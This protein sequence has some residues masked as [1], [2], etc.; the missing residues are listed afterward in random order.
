[1][2]SLLTKALT[3]LLMFCLAIPTM[4]E[5]SNSYKLHKYAP[6]NGGILQYVSPDGKWAVINLGTSA[7]GLTCPSELMNM[8]TGE[9]FGVKYQGRELSFNNVSNEDADGNVTIVGTFSLRPYAYRFNPSTPDVAGKLT[10]FQ[11]RLNWANGTLN[12]VTPDGKYAV[13]YFTDYTGKEAAG[14]EF[15]GEFWFD[16]L[17][18][19]IEKGIVMETPGLPTGDRNGIDQHAM[20]FNDITPDGRYILGEREWYMPSE[21]FQ[22]IY[23]V[24]KQDY[25]PI[26]FR[27]EGNRMIPEN[28]I[29][30]LDF[31]IMSHNGRYVGGIAVTYV[32]QDGSDMASEGRSPFRYDLETGEMTIFSDAESTA[33]D[34]GC[35]TD[36]GTIFGNP[37]TGSPLRNFRIF[38]QDKFWIPFSQLCQQQ[39]GFNFSQKTGFEFSGTATSVSGDGK[40]FVAFS[41][42][43]G[44]SFAFNFGKSVEEA[45]AS[46]DLLSNY[47]V[48]P[49][50]GAVTSRISTVEVNFGRAVQILG[51]GNTHVHLYKKGTDGGSDV[52]ICDGVSTESGIQF[53]TGSKNTVQF[54]I[55][56]RY[57]RL[58]NGAEYYFVIDEGA[59][60]PA[61]DA[62]MV[63]KQIRIKYIGRNDEPVRVIKCEPEDGVRMTNLDVQT[64]YIKLT[65]DCPVKMTEKYEAY[66]ERVEEGGN[67]VYVSPLAISYGNTEETKN[68]ILLRP[69]ST[70]YMYDGIEYHVVLTE[71]SI[72]D[73]NNNVSSYNKQWSM[74]IQGAYIREVVTDA[75]LFV[76]TFNSPNESLNKWIN[77]DG[78]HN[79]PLQEMAG[80]G[81]DAAN[82]PWNF[83]THDSADDPNYYATSHSLYAPS[84]QSDDWM[85]TRQVLIPEDGKAVLEFDALKRSPNK[86]DHLWI[87]IYEDDRAISYLNDNNMK[88]IKENMVLLDEITELKSCVDGQAGNN[89]KHYLYDLSAWAGKNIYVLFGNKNKNEDM[90]LVDNVKIQREILFSIGFSNDER[91]V[92]QDKL[93]IKGTF[94]IKTQD[95]ASGSI[96]LTLKDGE[97]NEVS[98]IGWQNISG[99]SLV[100]RPIP[101]NFTAPLPLVKGKENH[102][103]IDIAF[104]GKDHDGNDFKK[105]DTYNGII[106]N[107]VFTP[108]KRVV[109]E[110]MTGVTCPN[111][112]QGH[113]AIEECERQ[114]KDQ[115]IPVSIHS[116]DGDDLG[117]QFRGYSAFLGLNGAPSGRINRIGGTGEN[118]K[119]YYPMY[120]RGNNVYYDMPEAELW[121]NIVTQELEKLALFNLDATAIYNK[122]KDVI[123][124]NYS[125]N[126]ALDAEDQMLS[127][128][129]VILEDGIESYQ[130]NNFANSD[131]E[132][133]GEWGKGGIYGDYYAYPVIHNDVVRS[134]VGETFGGSIINKQTFEAGVAYDGYIG[135]RM[136]AAYN[137]KNKLKAVLMI[138]DNNSGEVINSCVAPLNSDDTGI[139]DITNDG[140]ANAPIYNVAGMRISSAAPA[141]LY[142]QNGKKLSK[143]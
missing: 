78:D 84:G 48:S 43:M 53:K 118:A 140:N 38:Y 76:D 32:E 137:D 105:G 119:T 81:F 9:H 39:Y 115:F 12:E 31:P 23:D 55:Q 92:A 89:W 68:Q 42:P 124:I 60:A 17:L 109:L 101:M 8:E 125:I 110:E 51:K 114:F 22:F 49:E 131:A 21:G 143:K 79:T 47:T 135:C 94:T 130:E 58:E 57:G 37:D 128:F 100:D 99:T 66:I 138:I 19:D 26:S 121:Y 36:K 18:V 52:L 91:V 13:G 7:S 117:A 93:D 106:Y 73:R 129:L 69:T 75:E 82:T 5:E 46:F 27:R 141:G 2:K 113:I 111:C 35:I 1:M 120:G 56:S 44:E 20:K 77:Y 10:V 72:C 83:S 98:R 95:F 74:T 62:S 86:N 28:D 116:Y 6:G 126:Y 59:V 16:A 112:P 103:S 122:E 87:Y 139:N 50:A 70:V 33:I 41:D 88:V 61:A 65:F 64:S 67:L 25:K 90:V 80:M 11:N 134:V 96:S 45:C 40:C 123:D 3:L 104:D 54:S 29:A 142:I 85:M 15:N 71:G 136:P 127:A 24:E 108:V 97:G 63:N 133:L 132:G 107:L 102:Y 34:V 30:Y 4:A 14:G